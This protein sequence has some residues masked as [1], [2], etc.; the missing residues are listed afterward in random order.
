MTCR[1]RSSR[2]RSARPSS[3]ARGVDTA[4]STPACGRGSS[5]SRRARTRC[6][7]AC[8][9]AR[10]REYVAVRGVRRRAAQRDRA[11]VPRGGLEPRRRGTRSTVGDAL[12][13]P[14]RARRARPAGQAREGAARARGSATST[15]SGSATSRST[16]RRARSPAARRSAPGSRRRSARRSPARS[17]S[18]TSP[19]WA[20]TRRDVPAAGARDA[21]AVARRQ[22]RAGGRARAAGGARLRSRDRAGPRR[23]A[24]RRAH[25]VRRHAGASSRSARDLPTGERVGGRRTMRR[26]ARR[27]AQR[28]ARDARGAG[29]T[30]CSGVDVAHPARRVCAVTGPER[31]GQVHARAR[32]S[33]TAR[34]RARSATCPSTRPGRTTRSTG[35]GALARAVLVDQSPLGRTARGNPATYTKAWDRIR[36]RFAA[37][38]EAARRGPHRRRTSPSTCAAGPLRGLRGRGLRD[39][40][41]AVP[42]RRA[43]CSARS[44]RASASSPRCSRSR[45]AA[46]ASPT[47]SR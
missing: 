8:C 33:S 13:A 30:T 22:H 2:R 15:R 3:T 5:G 16:G 42:R 11:R 38:P 39:R 28:V 43:R 25:P 37:E 7:C 24:A 17:S 27:Q 12:R 4:A 21:R 41:D 40:R 46:R 31:L 6:T 23:R 44:A 14:R 10:Y 1:G 18:S 47:C 32:T 19:P 20:C 45:T 35:I 34:R 29:A 36:A 9:S 26:G